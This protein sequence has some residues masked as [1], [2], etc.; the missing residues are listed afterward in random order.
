MHTRV[1]HPAKFFTAHDALEV[2]RTASSFDGA[3]LAT[4][5]QAFSNLAVLGTSHGSPKPESQPTVLAT[6]HVTPMNH[7]SKL[8]VFISLSC[9]STRATSSGAKGTELEKGVNGLVAVS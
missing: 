5:P 3:R 6:K 4:V 2:I 7:V 9:R 1:E 8:I